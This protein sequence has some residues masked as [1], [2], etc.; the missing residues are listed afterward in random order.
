MQILLQAIVQ[1]MDMA[2]CNKTYGW[3]NNSDE[4]IDG[5][6]DDEEMEE[7]LTRQKLQRNEMNGDDT[8]NRNGYDEINTEGERNG[9]NFDD[10]WT[11]AMV[12]SMVMEIS[13][14]F[15]KWS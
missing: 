8:I 7:I 1:K 3:N 2:W 9:N 10:I 5:Y 15:W 14:I 4:D 13:M 6:I 12:V 11:I